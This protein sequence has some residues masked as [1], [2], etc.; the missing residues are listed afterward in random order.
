VA[1]PTDTSTPVRSAAAVPLGSPR[2]GGTPPRS[3]DTALLIG[4]GAV[5]LGVAWAVATRR[6]SRGAP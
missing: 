2:T 5:S 3:S 1:A 4:I 6:R